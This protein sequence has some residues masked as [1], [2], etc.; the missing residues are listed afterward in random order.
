MA[1]LAIQQRD[2][3]ILTE[4]E[5]S[6]ACS[7][8]HLADTFFNGSIEAAKKRLQRLTNAGLISRNDG[9]P[10]GRTV[11]R[12]TKAGASLIAR[13]GS[14]SHNVVRPIGHRFL[15]HELLLTRCLSA[16]RRCLEARGRLAETVTSED[17][18]TFETHCSVHSRDERVTADAA[19]TVLG[20]EP[21][22][23]F[24][25]IDRST[26]SQTHLVHLAQQYRSYY[27]SRP[28]SGPDG[29]RCRMRVLLIMTSRERLNR[30]ATLLHE[31]SGIRTLVWLC[32][33]EDFIS[34]P[35][36]AN[37]RC[38]VDFAQSSESPTLRE[39]F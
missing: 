4:I 22:Y 27:K 19:T 13:R 34:D 3:A 17:K 30:T 21:E 24:F 1:T 23:F 33:A 18:V 5:C 39:L 31:F 16:F 36:K 20:V 2:L 12:L 7:R 32:L 8:K 29:E 37:W 15:Q 26:E 25:E 11:V 6:P 9:S 14:P 28:R 10:L 38:P 35:V